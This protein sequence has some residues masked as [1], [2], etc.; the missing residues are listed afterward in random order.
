MSEMLSGITDKVDSIDQN[1]FII[2]VK[3]VIGIRSH[4]CNGN[5][6]SKGSSAYAY[7]EIYFQMMSIPLQL[8]Q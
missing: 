1:F 8:Y 6:V 3:F 2:H 7:A 4:Q 5:I